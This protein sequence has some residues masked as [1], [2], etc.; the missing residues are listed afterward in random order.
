MS[1]KLSNIERA[2][3][4]SAVQ[5]SADKWTGQ[6]VVQVRD[7]VIATALLS[8]G[9]P[10]YESSPGMVLEYEG[11]DRRP[12]WNFHQWDKDKIVDA[13]KCATQAAK[14]PMEFC[15]DNP[16]NPFS[17][18]LMAL[19]NYPI[20]YR[21]VQTATP[22]IPMQAGEGVLLVT[23]GSRKHRAALK[24]GLQPIQAHYPKSKTQIE[25]AP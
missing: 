2:E 12:L 25:L 15:Q 17:F 8:V 5:A 11:E 13:R 1:E 3:K 16:T 19:L 7:V 22:L 4:I 23:K 18:A 20:M 6:V 14:D 9:V 10:L 21:G 24:R